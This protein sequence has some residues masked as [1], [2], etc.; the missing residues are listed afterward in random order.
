MKVIFDGDDTLWDT[1]PLY[2]KAR[3]EVEKVLQLRGDDPALWRQQQASIDLELFDA[4]G[5]S[6]D[7]FPTSFYL[8]ALEATGDE[9][10]A[11]C[12]RGLGRQPFL[13]AAKLR[14]GATEFLDLL[15][16]KNVGVGL[17]TR[18]DEAIQRKRIADS[19]LEFD[20]I[21]IVNRD[22]TVADFRWMVEHLVGD[23]EHLV[24][25]G[26]SYRSDIKPALA[27]G[28]DRCYW[29]ASSNWEREHVTG[30][31]E[32]L[33]EWDPFRVV[34]APS[35]AFIREWL[36]SDGLFGKPE[37]GDKDDQGDIDRDDRR[38]AV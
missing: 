4:M 22:K 24:S 28:F 12:A 26:D 13:E 19:G 37:P 27:A 1:E 17:I 3:N 32:G 9:E 7:R 23:E 14:P 35:F 33:G 10:F 36:R 29:M 11:E 20:H 38:M 18:G 34:I 25:I 8:S 21:E 31:F 2:E 5:F 15:H 30:Q 16:A 6:P